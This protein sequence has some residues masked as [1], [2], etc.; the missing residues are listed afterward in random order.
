MSDIPHIKKK[1]GRKPKENTVI[2]N[3]PVFADD[4]DSI[5]NLIIKLNNDKCDS[6]LYNELNDHETYYPNIECDKMSD[7]CWNC[8]HNFNL[9]VTGLPIKYN[10]GIFYTIGDFCTLECATR[11]AYENYDIYEI[12]PIINLYNN[13]KFKKTNKINMA[14]NKLI[15]KKFG[16]DVEIDEY[17]KQISVSYNVNLPIIHLKSEIS[18]YEF[19]NNTDNGLKIYRKK[20]N[21]SKNNI[22]NKMNLNIY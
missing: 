13:I 18:I 6:S 4:A 2:N 11:Y 20:S 14:P 12:I 21:K 8:C 15:L 10:N 16:G 22:F 19:K 1:R 3:N 7:I 17:R 9:S 5:D